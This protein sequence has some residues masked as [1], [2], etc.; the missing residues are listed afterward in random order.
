MINAD[1]AK[2]TGFDTSFPIAEDADFLLRAL[3]GKQYAVLP[4]SLYVYR[5]PSSTTLNKVSSALDY[6]CT[7]FQKQSD[8][9]PFDSAI[10]IAKARGK[11]LIYHSAATLGLWDYMIARR[12]RVPTAADYQQYRD[13]WQTVS[14]IA[15]GYGLIV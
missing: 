6:C 14:G 1:L 7:M 9:Y 13:A 11:Q 15:A 12:S 2:Q 4:R 8:R 5:E 10:E 3:L